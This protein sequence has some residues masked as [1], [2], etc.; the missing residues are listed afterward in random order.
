MPLVLSKYYKPSCP[1]GPGSPPIL[2]SVTISPNSG[3]ID[4]FLQINLIFFEFNL[5]YPNGDMGSGTFNW[6]FPPGQV[7]RH[8]LAENLTGITSGPVFFIHRIVT[9]SQKGT[10][11]IPTWLVDKAGNCSNIVYVDWTQ[12]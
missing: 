10:F 2:Y 3:P 6:D 1:G 4:T 7:V 8:Q 5:Y 11:S 9:S 12:Y